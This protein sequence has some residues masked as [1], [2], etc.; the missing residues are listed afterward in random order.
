MA[1]ISYIYIYIHAYTERYTHKKVLNV[2]GHQGT[3]S[4]N[5]SKI[6]LHFYCNG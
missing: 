1:Y 2:L 5:H 4:S 3:A 6:S